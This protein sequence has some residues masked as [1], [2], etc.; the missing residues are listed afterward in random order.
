MLKTRFIQNA[1]DASNERWNDAPYMFHD[2]KR[3]F[4]HKMTKL[5]DI[6]T[7]ITCIKA[8]HNCVQAAK[9][10]SSEA[11]N[12]QAILYICVGSEV[13]LTSNLWT[14][15]GL[16]NGSKGKVIDFV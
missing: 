14:E 5:K 16:H 2:N 11:N 7:P 10:D 4:E 9:R 1:T 8:H 12:L 6:G 15:V 13:M 3:C